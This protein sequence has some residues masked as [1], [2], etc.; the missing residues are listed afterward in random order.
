MLDEARGVCDAV[1]E[2][3]T[4]S[5]GRKKKGSGSLTKP[6]GKMESPHSVVS[7]AFP[8]KSGD[9][10]MERPHSKNSGKMEMP[11]SINSGKM[12]MPH[13][14]NSTNSIN[15]SKLETPILI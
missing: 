1:P 15:H 14:I 11:H 10:K 9:G 8:Y 5:G 2:V 12:E 7:P 13:S 4:V 6:P 3:E